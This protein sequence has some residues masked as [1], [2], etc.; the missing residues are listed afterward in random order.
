MFVMAIFFGC[1][2]ATHFALIRHASPAGNH[3]QPVKS[4]RA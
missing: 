2:Y 3:L 4:R 1:G